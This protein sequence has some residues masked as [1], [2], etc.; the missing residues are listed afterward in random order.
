MS[1]ACLVLWLT[2]D[3]DRGDLVPVCSVAAT[4]SR[5]SSNC[6]SSSTSPARGELIG[7]FLGVFPGLA[8]RV[9]P[10]LAAR[11]L[12]GLA[13][14]VLPGLAARGDELASAF[15]LARTVLLARESNGVL[16]GVL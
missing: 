12:L 2:G 8:A 11:V 6:G 7:S 4:C 3:V 1:A 15:A 13:A 14:R 16:W 9:L 10:G 5:L